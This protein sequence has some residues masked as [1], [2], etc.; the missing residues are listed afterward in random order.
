[1]VDSG[2]FSRAKGLLLQWLRWAYLRRE[3]VALL[4]FGA[5]QTR[6]LLQPKRAPRWNEDL[7]APLLGGGGTPLAAALQ[8]GWDMAAQQPQRQSCLWVISD[9]RSPD[10]LQLERQTAPALSQILVDCEPASAGTAK[11]F[12]GAARLSRAWP[13]SIRLSL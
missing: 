13:A 9:F 2:A 12:E 10:V 3:C 8:A 11:A 6:W 5:G 1:M 4:C 7:I